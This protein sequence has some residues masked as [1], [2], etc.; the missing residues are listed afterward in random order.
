MSLTAQIKNDIK[1]AMRAKEIIKRDTLRNIKASIKQIEVDG[2]ELILYF[3]KVAFRVFDQLR[4]LRPNHVKRDR[5]HHARFQK[6][7]YPVY[8]WSV[9]RAPFGTAVRWAVTQPT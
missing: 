1:E 3:Q 7:Q 5:R 4:S 2:K 9:P 6:G 8:Q